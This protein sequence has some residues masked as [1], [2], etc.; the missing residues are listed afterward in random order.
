MISVANGSKTNPDQLHILKS[1]NLSV[2]ILIHVL[3]CG[4]QGNWDHC[5]GLPRGYQIPQI[6]LKPPTSPPTLTNLISNM[7]AEPEFGFLTLQGS[8]GTG[9]DIELWDIPGLAF[10]SEIFWVLGGSRAVVPVGC[11]LQELQCLVCCILQH[12]LGS[13]FISVT[14]Y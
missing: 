8:L 4:I 3:L 7:P 1:R 10:G 9:D 11:S 2:K 14:C 12:V 5:V 6:P 13:F